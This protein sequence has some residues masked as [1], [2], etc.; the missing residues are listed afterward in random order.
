MGKVIA[1]CISDKK[2]VG[3]RDAG[4]AYF[5]KDWGIEHDAHGGDLIR[6]VSLLSYDKIKEFQKNGQDLALDTITIEH[7]AKNLR[8]KNINKN[9]KFIYHGAF[10]ENLVVEGIDFGSLPVGTVLKCGDVELVVS[11][12]G[13]ECHSPCSIYEKM[14]DCIMP[15]EGVFA[16]VVKEG[17]ISTGDKME[18]LSNSTPK[19]NAAILIISDKGSIGERKDESGPVIAKM[20][21]N[22]GYEIKEI[23]I[24]PDDRS[25]IEKM[26]INLSDKQQVNLIITTGG[27][28]FSKRDITPEAT[29]AV[30]ERIAPGIAEAIRS[31]S[32]QI[33]GRAMLSRGVSVIRGETIIVNLPGSPKA[34]KESLEFILPHLS[35]GL[36]VLCGTRGDCAENNH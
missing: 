8:D 20:L 1:V 32:M 6:Q 7:A 2:G 31:F 24:I 14:G 33:T 12:I 11:Q 13:K 9:P 5:I 29:L 22:A 19:F 17:V 10:G 4:S 28:G 21:S 18:V 34:V 30:A 3:K 25:V 26:L 35:H 27:T 23:K 15:R 36:E 16:R